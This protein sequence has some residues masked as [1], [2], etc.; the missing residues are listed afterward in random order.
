MGIFFNV[1]VTREVRSNPLVPSSCHPRVCGDP[2]FQ[3]SFPRFFLPYFCN[4]KYQKFFFGLLILYSVPDLF[5]K[6]PNSGAFG[7]FTKTA[8]TE[9]QNSQK[10]EAK[11]NKQVLKM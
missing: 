11:R 9:Y 3:S 7:I 4:Q 8:S 1:S 5:S 2:G 10:E 6:I